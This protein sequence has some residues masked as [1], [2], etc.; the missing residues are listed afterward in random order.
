MEKIA[1]KI[2][3]FTARHSRQVIYIVSQKRRAR[4]IRQ[5]FSKLFELTTLF[6]F[7]ISIV[8]YFLEQLWP[9]LMAIHSSILAWRIPWLGE[10]GGLQSIGSYRVE[11]D[12]SDLA[13]T[14]AH[15]HN[16]IWEIFEKLIYQN[17]TDPILCIMQLT[18]GF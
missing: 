18:N 12:W 13:Y 8:C 7:N 4:R 2:D 3:F 10:S 11:H 16:T 9:Y 6:Y 15:F 17:N 5:H 14:H 1:P